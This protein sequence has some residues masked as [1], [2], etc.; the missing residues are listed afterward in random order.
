MKVAVIS[1]APAIVRPQRRSGRNVSK[2]T[3]L[4]P[5]EGL[6]EMCKTYPAGRA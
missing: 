1:A 4:H 6:R 3:G 2:L 5:Q